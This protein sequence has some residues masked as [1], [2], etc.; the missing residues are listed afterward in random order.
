MSASDCSGAHA[1]GA[2][3]VAARKPRHQSVASAS[4]SPCVPGS[5]ATLNTG[6]HASGGPDNASWMLRRWRSTSTV[7]RLRF[8]LDA[9]GAGGSSPSPPQMTGSQSA[10]GPIGFGPTSSAVR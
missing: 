6:S 1:S 10:D 9:N 4:S 7:V 8:W 2:R 3:S 5:S